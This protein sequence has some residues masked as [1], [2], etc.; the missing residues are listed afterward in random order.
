MKLRYL[1]TMSRKI[2]IFTTLR[3]RKSEKKR[4]NEFQIWVHHAHHT[5]I[6]RQELAAD[7]LEFVGWSKFF[8]RIYLGM[9]E[10]K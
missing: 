2:T 10:K 5:E 7:N 6:E 9:K 1:T 4:E 8:T 3:D